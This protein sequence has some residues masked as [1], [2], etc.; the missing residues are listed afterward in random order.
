MSSS[1]I[2]GLDKNAIQYVYKN[3]K[4]STLSAERQQIN[5]FCENNIKP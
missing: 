1:G 3:L 4:K 2:P 5:E